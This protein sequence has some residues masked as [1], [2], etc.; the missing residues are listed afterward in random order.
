M[1]VMVIN[2]IAL[3]YMYIF[4]HLDLIFKVKT[5]LN[6]QT[7]PMKSYKNIIHR[8]KVIEEYYRFI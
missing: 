3:V 1:W 8:K 2:S 5:N 4:F 7:Q 6:A